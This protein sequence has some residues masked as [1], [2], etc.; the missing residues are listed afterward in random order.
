MNEGGKELR[1]EGRKERRRERRKEGRK[2]IIFHICPA[3]GCKGAY[4]GTMILY[5]EAALA[6]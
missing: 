4:T 3:Y 6:I 5:T 1:K 2:T